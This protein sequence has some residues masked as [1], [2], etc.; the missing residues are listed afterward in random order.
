MRDTQPTETTVLLADDEMLVLSLTGTVLREQGYRVLEANEP[1]E[2]LRICAE[3]DGPIDVLVT[4]VVM[5]QMN[6]REL[7]ERVTG[8]RP[9]IKVLYMS[10]YTEDTLIQ[11]GIRANEIAFLRKPFSIR[12]LE[13]KVHDLVAPA[14]PM[15]ALVA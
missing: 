13:A 4:D 5:P 10:G 9:G 11:H 14:D 1:G 6:G 2:A 8:L 7:A 12:T 15:P 3:H